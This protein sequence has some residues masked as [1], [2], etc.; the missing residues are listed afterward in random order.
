MLEKSRLDGDHIYANLWVQQVLAEFLAYPGGSYIGAP[1][2]PQ[3]QY[4]RLQEQRLGAD[5]ADKEILTAIRRAREKT[6]VIEPLTRRAMIQAMNLR[7]TDED[8]LEAALPHSILGQPN[9]DV[10][11]MHAYSYRGDVEMW[12]QPTGGSGASHLHHVRLPGCPSFDAFQWL[13]SDGFGSG[14]FINEGFDRLPLGFGR[15]FTVGDD[16][17][18]LLPMKGGESLDPVS[19]VT[20]LTMPDDGM[21]VVDPNTQ[22]LITWGASWGEARFYHILFDIDPDTGLPVPVGRALDALIPEVN[23]DPRGYKPDGGNLMG[24]RDYEFVAMPLREY[25]ETQVTSPSSWANRDTEVTYEWDPPQLGGFSY[26]SWVPM[27]KVFSFYPPVEALGDSTLPPYVHTVEKYPRGA[28]RGYIDFGSDIWP[29]RTDG[30]GGDPWVAPTWTQLLARVQDPAL[31][32][33][34]VEAWM[35]SA[36]DRYDPE[37]DYLHEWKRIAGGGEAF[38]LVRHGWTHLRG[39]A[40]ANVSIE[41]LAAFPLGPSLMGYGTWRAPEQV[42]PVSIQQLGSDVALIAP[43]MATGQTWVRLDGIA[44]PSH[45]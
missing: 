7:W 13:G 41:D 4:L 23:W 26:F 6:G 27:D 43:S 20:G 8:F 3:A 18:G 39:W 33:G 16:Q 15:W 14:S 21:L 34:A 9:G 5:P 24:Y 22:R 10:I 28:G 31:V 1:M 2:G 44:Y 40:R 25:P 45:G 29:T 38:Y 37:D 11:G 32:D 17:L 36:L 35:L 19:D 30:L 42:T 12:L